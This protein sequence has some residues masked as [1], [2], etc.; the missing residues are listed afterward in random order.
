METGYQRGRIQ[1]E[2]MLY[3]QRKHDGTLPI[4]GVNTFR[5]PRPATRPP[6]VE[7]ARGHRGGEEVPAGPGPRLPANGTADEAH[8]A[9]AALQGG[10][11]LAA[12]T[13][14]RC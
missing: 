6:P 10:G 2:S 14:S 7:L 5:N 9:L 12:A 4:I 8:A 1:D 3:E 11:A 13:C